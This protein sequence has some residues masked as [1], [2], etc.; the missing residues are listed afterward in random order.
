MLMI[1]VTDQNKDK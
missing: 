1:L